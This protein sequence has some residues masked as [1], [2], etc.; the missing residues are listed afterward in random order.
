MWPLGLL[1]SK[2]G[3]KIQ[4]MLRSILCK[5]Q[6][7]Q[8]GSGHDMSQISLIFTVLTLF[9]PSYM[10]LAPLPKFYHP[11][12]WQPIAAPG[13]HLNTKIQPTFPMFYPCF[14]L[15]VESENKFTVCVLFCHTV[16]SLFMLS[17]ATHSKDYV[18]DPLL[19]VV[20]FGTLPI[21]DFL[22]N[23][24]NEFKYFAKWIQDIQQS[25]KDSHIKDTLYT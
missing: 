4:H 25:S 23:F 22:L 18:A 8:I 9:A 1:F 13:G 6:K 16:F 15:K 17:T 24:I 7:N 2:L 10:N 20:Q 11:L 3:Q 21:S 5:N 12:P 14:P 19:N